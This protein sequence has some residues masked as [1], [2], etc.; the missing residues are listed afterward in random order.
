MKE[1]QASKYTLFIKEKMHSIRAQ[2]PH[3]S[4]PEIMKLAA[5][6][7]KKSEEQVNTKFVPM[8]DFDDD[9]IDSDTENKF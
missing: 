4:Q 1:R 5:A 7:Y 8:H 9:A 6:L 3:L 2:N